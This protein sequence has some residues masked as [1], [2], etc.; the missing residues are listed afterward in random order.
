MPSTSWEALRASVERARSPKDTG[1]K[2]TSPSARAVGGKRTPAAKKRARSGSAAKGREL[3]ALTKAELYEKAA[4]ADIPGRSSMSH[5]QLADAL[6]HTGR[7]RRR[8]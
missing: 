6:A 4:A 7:G 3:M 5:D 1:D 2:A 8:A